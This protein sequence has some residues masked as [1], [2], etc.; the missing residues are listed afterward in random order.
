MG[1]FART[2][3]FIHFSFPHLWK[4]HHCM[5]TEEFKGR[6]EN[7]CFLDEIYRSMT[8]VSG[9]SKFQMLES[10]EALPSTEEKSVAVQ[11]RDRKGK[12]D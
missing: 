4:D 10:H 11:T 2:R 7:S 6:D 5:N 1:G 12:E 8:L 9:M 3:G